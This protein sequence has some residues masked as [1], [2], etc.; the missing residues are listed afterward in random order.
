MEI[1]DQDDEIARDPDAQVEATEGLS[2]NGEAEVRSLSV[3]ENLRARLRQLERQGSGQPFRHRITLIGTAELD[4]AKPRASRSGALKLLEAVYEKGE[5]H[6]L[7]PVSAMAPLKE[8]LFKEEAPPGVDRGIYYV[9]MRLARAGISPAAFVIHVV[10]PRMGNDY[11]WRQWRSRH[12]WVLGSIADLLIALRSAH[13]WNGS[14]LGTSPVI[15]DVALCKYVGRPLARIPSERF[16][17]QEAH[18]ASWAEAWKSFSFS[19]AGFLTFMRRTVLPCLYRMSGKI[20]PEQLAPIAT[21]LATLERTLGRRMQAMSPTAAEGFLATAGLTD[22]FEERMEKRTASGAG[23]WAVAMELHGYA[24]LASQLATLDAGPAVLG[25]AAA[26]SLNADPGYLMDAASLAGILRRDE[27]AALAR[28]H[29]EDLARKSPAD[30]AAYIVAVAANGGVHPRCPFAFAPTFHERR[31][32]DAEA[33]ASSLGLDLEPLRSNDGSM[34]D[35]ATMRRALFKTRP[36]AARLYA[37][38]TEALGSGA[39]RGWNQEDA[40]RLDALGPGFHELA[41]RSLIP[42]LGTGFS[43]QALKQ[44]S[45]CG[46]YQA[47]GA[48]SSGSLIVSTLRLRLGST[49]QAG[50]GIDVASRDAV[51][52]R[53]A[54]DIIE[55]AWSALVS[56]KGDPECGSVFA[57]LGKESAAA[58]KRLADLKAIPEGGSVGEHDAK[59]IRAIEARLALMD[60]AFEALKDI[61]PAT[62]DPRRF[63]LAMHLAGHFFKPGDGP[64]FEAMAGAAVRY[65]K[66]GNFSSIVARLAL[67]VA[68]GF[69]GV[70]QAALVADAVDALCAACAADDSVTKALG[71]AEG[72]LASALR[73]S[74]RLRGGGPSAE[75]MDAALRRVTAYARITAETAKW[76]D[77]LA[78]LSS[79][80][81]DQ[82]HFTLRTSRGF[83]D[84]YYGDMGG[85]CLSG[86]PELILRPG[87][88]VC[89]LWDEDEHRIRGMC[90]FVLSTG[91]ARSAGMGKFWYAFAFNPLRSLMRG[92][93][94]REL[95]TLYLGFRA[96]AE[97]ISRRS[98]LPVLVPGIG[99]KGILTHGMVSNDGTF[100]TLVANY[101]QAAG[102]PHVADAR[103][104]DVYYP[105]AAFAD[106]LVIVD[107]KR[108]GSYRAQ[109]ELVKLKALR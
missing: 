70:E 57:E 45:M 97:E 95:A 3:S 5:E 73:G 24:E 64:P 39:D 19:S 74:S 109:A 100:A 16:S 12:V 21:S 93:G 76:R 72:E 22:S 11:D 20:D 81:P 7:D 25:R 60:A 48:A 99:P 82:K 107:P 65:G 90:L 105:K 17:A 34:P 96:S 1:P 108:P 58:R 79:D 75:S 66:D 56:G 42:G 23:A 18:L 6:W 52:A 92:I 53:V 104:F 26:I 102:S 31:S 13:P 85:I 27:G 47:Y 101:E 89:R 63:A 50:K 4:E 44:P 28:W 91:P 36:E 83:L 86:F 68:P 40:S 15:A 46:L 61:P 62:R 14:R 2:G 29:L 37:E 33:L 84:A 78:K 55:S 30:R 49:G 88:I 51:R 9:L 98:A 8:I 103:G 43:F 94:S 80:K 35:L 32:F 54:V 10:L 59:A 106:A 71:K 41:I 87:V 77:L 67:D 69:M 38:M